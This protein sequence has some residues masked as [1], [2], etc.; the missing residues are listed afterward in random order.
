MKKVLIDTDMLTYY[1]FKDYPQVKQ[2]F[3]AYLAHYG[4]VYVGR[5]T[6]FEIESGL[7]T[8]KAYKKLEQF[9]DFIQ[10]QVILEI[11]ESSAQ[12]SAQIYAHLSNIGKHSGTNDL[13]LAGIARS[14]DFA[15]CTNNEKDYENIPDLEIVNWAKYET[16]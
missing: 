6:I 5:P 7:L 2:H 9:H 8:K 15:I 13:Y 11:T 12:I 4:F 14:N 10:Q 3:E 1:L 16:Q